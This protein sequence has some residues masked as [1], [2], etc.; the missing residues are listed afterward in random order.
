MMK[1]CLML[2]RIQK[3]RGQLMVIEIFENENFPRIFGFFCQPKLIFIFVFFICPP[4]S[5]SSFSS[6]LQYFFP[7]FFLV[8][9]YYS[10]RFHLLKIQLYD[11]FFV[12]LDIFFS[13][14]KYSIFEIPLIFILNQSNQTESIY[15]EK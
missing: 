12:F 8:F 6:F 10:S 2:Q 14:K 13:P 15:Q 5:S 4:L 3:K 7:V 1:R 9:F 11:H